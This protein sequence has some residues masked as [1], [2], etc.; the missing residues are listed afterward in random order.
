MDK[1]L[2][3]GSAMDIRGICTL[4][5][6]TDAE[7]KDT[8]PRQNQQPNQQYQQTYQPYQQPNQQYQQ[9]YQNYL[10]NSQLPYEHINKRQERASVGLCILS[11]LIPLAGII[12]Y[13]VKRNESKRPA[14]IYKDIALV[15]TA[16]EIFG[17]FILPRLLIAFVH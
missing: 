11:F 6:G 7:V 4:C 1:C 15:V 17:T 13:F 16:M 3:C 5:G 10:Q 9:A 12:L 2:K 14:K 8:Q